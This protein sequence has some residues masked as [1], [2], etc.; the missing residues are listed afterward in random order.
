MAEHVERA[1][2]VELFAQAGK[3]RLADGG[4]VVLGESFPCLRLRFLHPGEHVGGKERAGAVV[5]GG[6]ALRMEPA[7]RGEMRADLV[8]ETDLLVGAAHGA[9]R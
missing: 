4:A 2:G 1:A 5:A 7:V 3:Q 8:L 9:K 6:I